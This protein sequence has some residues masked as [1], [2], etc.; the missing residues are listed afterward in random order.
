MDIFLNLQ[1]EQYFQ[2]STFITTTIGM[3]KGS[4]PCPLSVHAFDQSVVVV[5][6]GNYTALC[7][8][9]TWS[10]LGYLVDEINADIQDVWPLLSA[11]DALAVAIM[12]MGVHTDLRSSSMSSERSCFFLLRSNLMRKWCSKT[13]Y[14]CRRDCYVWGKCLQMHQLFLMFIWEIECAALRKEK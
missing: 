11:S 3:S 4:C 6:E 13:L 9:L 10:I 14:S 12:F 1:T 5:M 2:E 7:G 8:H